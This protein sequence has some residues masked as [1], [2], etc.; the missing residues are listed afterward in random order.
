MFHTHRKQTLLTLA[1]ASVLAWQFSST[2]HAAGYLKLG[3]IKGE[4]TDQ[5]HS[6]ELEVESWSW[7]ETN[8]AASGKREAATGMP[9]GKR[10]HKPLMIT[11]LVDKA[12]P[13]LLE[14]N[15]KGTRF[16]SMTLSLPNPDSTQQGYMVY[17]FTDVMISSYQTSGSDGS[18]PMETISFNYSKVES[19]VAPTEP[20]RLSTD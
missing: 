8:V 11:K 9:T 18:I 20:A 14:A 19:E 7:G 12:S 17:T 15:A 2:A 6:G 1:L 4:S 5:A 13:K 10:Q 3:D 16:A